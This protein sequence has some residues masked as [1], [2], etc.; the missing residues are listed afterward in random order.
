MTLPFFFQVV[1]P[2]TLFNR[3]APADLVDGV[4]DEVKRLFAGAYGGYTE[5][6]ASGGYVAES[7]ELIAETVY[8]VSAWSTVP[9]DQ[10]LRMAVE[11]IR[12][13][14]QQETVLYQIGNRTYIE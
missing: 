6:R 13:R 5:T 4:R 9:D 3:T 12:T 8:Q 2:T 7:G 10:P 11:V 14:L 1:I